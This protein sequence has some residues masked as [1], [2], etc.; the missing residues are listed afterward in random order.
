VSRLISLSQKQ[1]AEVGDVAL[2]SAQSERIVDWLL[3]SLTKLSPFDYGELVGRQ[4]LHGKLDLATALAKEKL[5]NQPRKKKALLAL[6]GQLK[7]LN[8]KRSIVIH[9]EWRPKGG[10]RLSDFVDFSKFQNGVLDPEWIHQKRNKQTRKITAQELASLGPQI[11]AANEQLL[12]FWLATW[13]T[14]QVV[15]S[16]RRRTLKS[17]PQSPSR[18]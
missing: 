17:V 2:E 15:R 6:L 14:P 18:G 16:A 9:G 11:S 7:D 5:K 1:R 8:E 12:Q 10:F 13:I 3:A 4:M